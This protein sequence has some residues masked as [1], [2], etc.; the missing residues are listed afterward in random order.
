MTGDHFYEM[1]PNKFYHYIVY[2]ESSSPFTKKLSEY[3]GQKFRQ[4]NPELRVVHGFEKRSQPQVDTERIRRGRMDDSGSDQY[5][6]DIKNLQTQIDRSRRKTDDGAK[7][8]IKGVAGQRQ[9]VRM[10]QLAPT[11]TRNYQDPETGEYQGVSFR[12]KNVLVVDDNIS[13]GGTA[14]DITQLIRQ[15]GPRNVDVYVPLHAKF[16]TAKYK[17]KPLGVNEVFSAEELKEKNREDV[18]WYTDYLPSY[19]PSEGESG[20]SSKDTESPDFEQIDGPKPVSDYDFVQARFHL[21]GTEYYVTF[22]RMDDMANNYLSMDLEV[23]E[24][25]WDTLDQKDFA[26]TNKNTPFQ[27]MSKVLAI[28]TDFTSEVKPEAIYYEPGDDMLGNFYNRIFPKMFYNY[29]REEV[30]SKNVFYIRKDVF[31]PEPEQELKPEPEQELK[32]ELEQDPMQ[33]TQEPTNWWNN[34]SPEDYKRAH[35]AGIIPDQEN[36]LEPKSRLHKRLQSDL[37]TKYEQ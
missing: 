11:A 4:T 34:L 12:N 24:I 5:K 10:M 14:Q 18:R 22:N 27:V 20:F 9:F 13:S 23:Y 33:Q 25:S 29:E 15:Q 30:G 35:Q 1:N 7:H 37:Q 31:V 28:I 36:Y 6:K 16:H 3:L 17:G 21:N 26:R 2:P 32:P 8:Q 19:H